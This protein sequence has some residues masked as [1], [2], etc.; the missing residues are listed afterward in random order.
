MGKGLEGKSYGLFV[1]PSWHMP[2]GFEENH[3]NLSIA[4]VPTEI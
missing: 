3:E 2:G 4:S 1:V